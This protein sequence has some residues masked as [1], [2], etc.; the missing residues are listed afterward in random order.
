MMNTRAMVYVPSGKETDGTG[1]YWLEK[2]VTENSRKM[3]GICHYSEV[4]RE[5][6]PGNLSNQG[7][8]ITPNYA[9]PSSAHACV[10]APIS[11][12]GLKISACLAS[13]MSCIHFVTGSNTAHVINL[14]VGIVGGMA[15]Y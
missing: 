9:S 2:Y 8:I 15:K 11:A 4:D 1:R 10:T 12:P 7:I 13:T 3:K 5:S 14:G 6:L